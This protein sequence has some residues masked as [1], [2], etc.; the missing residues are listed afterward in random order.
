MPDGSVGRI[1]ITH[2]LDRKYGLDEEAIKALK[3]WRFRPGMLNGQPVAVI[4]NVELS[5]T[6]KK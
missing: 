2:S 5:F 1:R 6:L 4:V 3:R